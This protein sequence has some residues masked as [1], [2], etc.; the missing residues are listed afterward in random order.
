MKNI[1]KAAAVFLA[2]SG[3]LFAGDATAPYQESRID[4]RLNLTVKEDTQVLHFVRDNVDPDVVTKTYVLKHADP[5]E[6]RRYLREIVQTRKVD[7]ADTGI[8]AI[9][10]NDGTGIV[11]VSAEDYRFE[12]SENGQGIDTII[13]TLDKPKVAS[14]TGQPIYV[15][16]PKFRPAKEL[17]D[18]VQASGADISGDVTENIGGSDRIRCDEGLNLMMFKT[19]QFSRKNIER[20]L[21]EYDRPYPE[22]KAKIT[23]YEI[24][25]ENDAKI[26]LDFQAWK[27]NDGIDLFNGGARFMQNYAPDGANLVKGAGWS[28]TKYF[29]FNPKWNTKYIDFLTSK[30]KAKVLHSCEVAVRNEST[31]EI[32]RTSSVFLSTNE[33]IESKEFTESYLS[34]EDSTPGTDFELTARTSGGKE[35][36][37]SAPGAVTLT[38]LKMAAPSVTQAEKY[39]LTLQDGEFQID[40]Q[41]VGSKVN[42]GFAEVTDLSDPQNPEVLEFTNNNV[43]AMKGNKINTTASNEFGFKMSISPSVTDKATLLAVNLSNSSLIGYKSNGEARIQ[44]GAEISSNFMIS[45]EGTKLVI[46]GIEKRDVVSVSGGIPIL[47]DI[48][49]LGWIFSTES[50]STKKSQLLVV[51]EVVPVRPGEI[52]AQA[53]A[54]EIKQLEDKLNNAGE[55]NTFGYRQF[56]LDDN[57]LK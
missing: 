17:R 34:V 26:G 56:M 2:A 54:E 12:D 31:A 22:V 38:V 1:T 28:D 3:S 46:G 19:T 52:L 16:N 13:A 21:K 55:G 27:N 24:Y 33:P 23:V 49:L 50:E 15:Y 18:M 51:A 43:A 30:G 36:T 39:V 32:K 4:A 45:N 6:I 14:V 11:M 9:K 35:I 20:A 8:Q 41:N 47:K 42:A 5:Y 25:A 37:I 10:Y 40:G 57:R 48:P 7:E 29:N 44:Q 53:N